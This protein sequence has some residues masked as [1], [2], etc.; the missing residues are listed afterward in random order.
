MRPPVTQPVLC[1]AGDLDPALPSRALPASA[2]HVSGPFEQHRVPGVG[3]FCQEEDPE[4]VNALLLDWL[5]RL[6]S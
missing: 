6:P 1:L 2:E 3:H 5:A 4:A